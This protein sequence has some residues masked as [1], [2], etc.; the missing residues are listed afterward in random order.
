[1]ST[2]KVSN[3]ARQGYSI[4]FPLFLFFSAIFCMSTRT[5]N[6][7]HLSILLLLLS[8][9]R[10]ENRQALAEPIAIEPGFIHAERRTGLMHQP[11]I[12]LGVRA[13]AAAKGVHQREQRAVV[14]IEQVLFDA[15]AAIQALQPHAVGLAEALDKGRF[16][17][18]P[19]IVDH[20]IAQQQLVVTLVVEQQQ[21]F[22]VN[23]D[24]AAQPPPEPEYPVNR[25]RQAVQIVQ[26]Q[27]GGIELAVGASFALEA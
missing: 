5:N 1:M 22:I 14:L 27:A 3:F 23:Q 6:L 17:G 2:L 9:V 7:L 19:G 26:R 8:L 25:A 13:A 18:E 20:R 24:L 12:I 4:V 10:Q 15:P 21:V 16:A 11:L